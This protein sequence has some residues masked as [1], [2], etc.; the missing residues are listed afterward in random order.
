MPNAG[1]LTNSSVVS[2]L[3]TGAVGELGNFYQSNRINGSNN[4]YQNPNVLGANVLTNYS[5]S[6]YNGLQMEVS[7]RF[8]KGLSLQANYVWSKVL[9]DSQGNQQTDFEPFLDINNAKIERSRTQASD[10]RQVFKTNFNYDLPFGDGHR[11]NASHLSRVLSGWKAAGIFTAQTG[12][13]FSILSARGT[14]NRSARSTYNTI[15]TNLTGSQLNDLFQLRMTGNGPM[16]VAASAI[17]SDNRA[18]APDGTAAFAGQAFFQPA[19]GTIGALQRMDMTGPS[20]WNL[21]FNMKKETKITERHSIELRM[22]AT[23]V[24]NHATWYVGNQTVTSTTFGKI[25]SNYYGRRLVQFAL[26][27]KF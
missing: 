21:D 9:S 18:V 19:A 27:Y 17:G 25:T 6:S 5:N 4:Y 16:Y 23:N 2:Y 8:S 13:P 1:Y 15:N 20:V 7:R 3:Q 12:T 11:L 14:L 24:F 26:Y 22:D 10:L